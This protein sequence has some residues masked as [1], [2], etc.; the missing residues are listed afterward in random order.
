MKRK[1]YKIM[2]L[3]LIFFSVFILTSCDQNSFELETTIIPEFTP[4]SG[5][6]AVA[7]PLGDLLILDEWED[8]NV[9]QELFL[10]QGKPKRKVYLKVVAADF[11]ESVNFYYTIG[12]IE[13]TTQPIKWKTLF[14]N[15]DS[16]PGVIWKMRDGKTITQK[17]VKEEK[18]VIEK[19]N[20]PKKKI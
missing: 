6:V 3:I 7:Y 10:T 18:E 5:K 13:V 11:G 12:N 19:Q 17:E 1:Q 8:L 9:A 14:R 2:G 16:I 4:Y 15:V 20:Q